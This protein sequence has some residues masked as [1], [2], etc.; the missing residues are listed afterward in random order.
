MGHNTKLLRKLRNK[1]F[2]LSASIFLVVIVGAFIAVY[3]NTYINVQRE[4]STR[5]EV[6]RA[7]ARASLP[8]DTWSNSSFN[9]LADPLIVRI[10]LSDIQEILSVY[11][12]L[13]MPDYILEQLIDPFRSRISQATIHSTPNNGG[14]SVRWTQ[15]EQM[16]TSESISVGGRDWRVVSS[17]TAFAVDNIEDF[18]ISQAGHSIIF[19]DVTDFNNTLSSLLHTLLIIGFIV[20]PIVAGMSYYFA[21]RAVKPIAEAWDKQKQF[22]ADA[23][24]ELKTP[25]TIIK[26]NLG[27]V[28][29]NSNEAVDTQMEWLGYVKTGAERMSRLANDLLSLANADSS[30]L[31]IKKENFNVSD[32]I[33]DLTN[34]MI[35]RADEK[36]IELIT[37]V[38]SDVFIHSDQ[39][40]ITQI[41]T[42]LFDNATKYTELNGSINISLDEA[43]Q[44]ICLTV[45]NSG[46]GIKKTELYNIFDR[47]YQTEPSRNSKN[48][49][50]GLGLS[51]AQALT[52]K[53]GGKLS[54]VSGENENT[55]F[56]FES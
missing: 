53:I 22:I 28:M 31:Q 54:V 10:N 25:I 30:D 29:S 32:T 45:T 9:R 19:M 55:T 26:S 6:A 12:L 46:K 49:G 7:D 14:T 48:E 56:T 27:I 15:Y 50:F 41:A 4:I 13:D 23:S 36:G 51:I 52:E 37:S 16:D 2:A 24:H 40:K 34:A 39:E 21:K 44:G 18:G 38:K 1:F 11:S 3:V 17:V 20:F 5:L 35:A 8:T 42:I 47:F 33:T 43:N